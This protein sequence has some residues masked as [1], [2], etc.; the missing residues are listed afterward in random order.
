M[1]GARGKWEHSVYTFK[2]DLTEF[3]EELDV[4]VKTKRNPGCSWLVWLSGLSAGL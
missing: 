3:P 1:D 2:M 4:G